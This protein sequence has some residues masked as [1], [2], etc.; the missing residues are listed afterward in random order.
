M[1]MASKAT[2][3]H[4]TLNALD[5]DPDEAAG[6]WS[7]VSKKKGRTK[8]VGELQAQ[9]PCSPLGGASESPVVDRSVA[10]CD[11]PSAL[12]ASRKG[13]AGGG[14][15]TGGLADPPWRRAQAETSS[16][17]AK[18]VEG[19]AQV[20]EQPPPAAVTDRWTALDRTVLRSERTPTPPP[21]SR[22]AEGSTPIKQRPPVAPPWLRQKQRSSSDHSDHAASTLEHPGSSPSADTVEGSFSIKERS[23][24]HPSTDRWA[25]L[26]P[27]VRWPESETGYQR[28]KNRHSPKHVPAASPKFKPAVSPQLQPA[29]GPNLSPTDGN[30][31]NP[32]R[33]RDDVNDEIVWVVDLAK[34]MLTRSDFNVRSSQ[35]LHA[36]HQK[37][38]RSKVHEAL[39]LVFDLTTKS[40]DTI[41]NRPGYVSKLLKNFFDDRK[42]EVQEQRRASHENLEQ[43]SETPRSEKLGAPIGARSPLSTIGIP[44][45]LIVQC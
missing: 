11:R 1:T 36:I 43:V 39:N 4:A 44:S 28:S 32:R 31:D 23:P 17:S 25:V 5:A 12:T 7:C 40:R 21:S 20:E 14:D 35:C 3:Q 38:G 41:K 37:G 9:K 15:A 34:G 27:S 22:T 10:L 8:H 13:A 30:Q 42:E 19:S 26:D 24:L 6:E 45:S 18:L 2:D 16:P 29:D 33:A